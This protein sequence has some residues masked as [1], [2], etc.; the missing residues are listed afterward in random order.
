MRQPES[1]LAKPAR[2]AREPDHKLGNFGSA[3]RQA[4]I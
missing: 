1:L 2:G 4:K 3:A